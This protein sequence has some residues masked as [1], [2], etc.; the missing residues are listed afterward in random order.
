MVP[1]V[2]F[3]W[4]LMYKNLI[5]FT[6]LGLSL[7]QPLILAEPAVCAVELTVTRVVVNNQ[8]SLPNLCIGKFDSE[9]VLRKQFLYKPD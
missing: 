7:L 5:W 9:R 3:E 4:F 8:D 1:Y 6:T 2:I